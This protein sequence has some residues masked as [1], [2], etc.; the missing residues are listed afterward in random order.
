M[1]LSWNSNSD[2]RLGLI[3]VPWPI[4]E[5]RHVLL[6]IEFSFYF[7]LESI[8][9]KLNLFNLFSIS[10]YFSIRSWLIAWMLFKFYFKGD[11]TESTEGTL[12]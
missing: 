7:E 6:K 8:E 5:I 12:F 1:L 10:C 3:K 4:F 2:V 11:L 9:E